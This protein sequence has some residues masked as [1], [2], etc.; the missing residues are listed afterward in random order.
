MVASSLPS[1]WVLAGEDALT[2][3][4]AARHTR[5]P[6]GLC[7]SPP[8]RP[9]H[10]PGRWPPRPVRRARA[11][12]ARTHAGRGV[13]TPRHRARG[14]PARAPA[15]AGATPASI[16]PAPPVASTTTPPARLRQRKATASEAR[17]SAGPSP[18]ASSQSTIGGPLMLTEVVSAPLVKPIEGGGRGAACLPRSSLL[19]SGLLRST[20]ARLPLDCRSEDHSGADG[21]LQHRLRQPCEQA[22]A[23]QQPRQRGQQH[24]RS[25]R[26]PAPGRHRRRRALAG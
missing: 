17:I 14:R 11:P 10:R 5:V 21:H 18:R 15:A 19:R 4:S 23:E 16:A 24:R 13:G 9:T 8:R 20:G 25:V 12:C 3:P 26:G 22:G 2:D 6:A 1:S 7:L